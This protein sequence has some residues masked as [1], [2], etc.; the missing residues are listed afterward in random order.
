MD[1]AGPHQVLDK[2]LVIK[3]VGLATSDRE[4]EC[5]KNAI[6][7]TSGMSATRARPGYGFQGMT[8]RWV[9]VE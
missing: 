2:D 5:L 8:E 6:F 1:L 7:K 3:L 9:R 4:R